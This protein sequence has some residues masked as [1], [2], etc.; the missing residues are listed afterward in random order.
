MADKW[1]ETNFVAAAFGARATARPAPMLTRGGQMLGTLPVFTINGERKFPNAKG[2]S[3]QLLVTHWPGDEG[4]LQ[5]VSGVCVTDNGRSAAFTRTQVDEVDRAAKKE[6]NSGAGKKVAVNRKGA[7]SA[8]LTL[9]SVINVAFFDG[10]EGSIVHSARALL[11]IREAQLDPRIGG[12]RWVPSA[13]RIEKRLPQMS[14][15][16]HEQL[17]CAMVHATQLHPPLVRLVYESRDVLQIDVVKAMKAD[18]FTPATRHMKNGVFM[19]P[20]LDYNFSRLA[21]ARGIRGLDAL[22]YTD[23]AQSLLGGACWPEITVDKDTKARKVVDMMRYRFV[24]NQL[25]RKDGAVPVLPV[26]NDQMAAVF[27]MR[28]IGITVAVFKAALYSWG[29]MDDRHWFDDGALRYLIAATPAFMLARATSDAESSEMHRE[30]AA[31]ELDFVNSEGNKEDTRGAAVT[32]FLADGVVN[33]GY[34]IDRDSMLALLDLLHATNKKRYNR[35]MAIATMRKSTTYNDFTVPDHYARDPA[36]SPHVINILECLENLEDF[37]AADWHFVIIPNL[38]QKCEAVGSAGHAFL[39]RLLAGEGGL[40]AAART[41]GSIMVQMQRDKEIRE[42]AD[43]R[44]AF[45]LVHGRFDFLLWAVSRAYFD[46]RKFSFASSRNHVPMLDAFF[47]K[48]YPSDGADMKA[49]MAA[50][51]KATVAPAPEAT[52]APGAEG[53]KAAGKRESDADEPPAKRMAPGEEEISDADMAAAA[54]A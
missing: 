26:T 29:V 35:N 30:S 47:A 38:G 54:D 44:D 52:V 1:S 37:R 14:A 13:C 23:V 8:V 19:L 42:P 41:M 28:S 12:T 22:Q 48:A 15:A 20:L 6:Q 24:V 5:P 49:A 51:A 40:D 9:G 21:G 27:D 53:E 25:T 4:G 2:R 7:G 50:A 46:E 32:T 31:Y 11:S 16:E 10:E 3:A 34:P 45:R 43:A 17:M 18:A 39:C 33:A 36:D